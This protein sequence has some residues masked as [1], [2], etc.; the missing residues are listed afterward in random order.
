MEWIVT[1]KK[2]ETP[3]TKTIRFKPN[4]PINFKPGQYFV[5]HDL[6]D[7][8]EDCRAY[9]ASSSP[10][11]DYIEI[12]VKLVPNPHFSKHLH[13]LRTNQPIEVRGPYGQFYF[14]EAKDIVLIGAG[15]GIAPLRAIIQYIQDKQLSTNVTLIYS[16]KTS[17]L[18][19][20]KK[21][22]EDLEKQG[23]LHLYITLTQE[24]GQYTGRISHDL[25]KQVI[26]GVAKPEFFICGPP[27]MVKKTE[28]ILEQIGV[29]K[30]HIKKEAF[31]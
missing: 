22:L 30:K 2:T 3:G 18:V 10:L 8:L 16:A 28:E 24:K 25:I 15:S 26:P 29:P 14:E 7:W 6:V 27:K 11:R 1:D 19:I 13:E 23:K 12:T 31:A 17:Q 5:F 20:Y 9:S 21:E 4:K